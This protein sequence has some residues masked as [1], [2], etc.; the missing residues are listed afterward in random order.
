MI[1]RKRNIFM[2]LALLS[3]I[4]INFS[5]NKKSSAIDPVDQHRYDS[6]LLIERDKALY[7]IDF[8]ISPA[9]YEADIKRFI[10]EH[11]NSRGNLDIMGSEYGV[12]FKCF[13]PEMFYEKNIY[14]DSKFINLCSIEDFNNYENS[15][16]VYNK[17]S[18]MF[19]NGKL[20]SFNIE[21]MGRPLNDSIDIKMN[22]CVS[23]LKKL[24]ESRYGKATNNVLKN[25]IDWDKANPDNVY[26]LEEWNMGAKSVMIYIRSNNSYGNKNVYVGAT[27]IS[28]TI[29]QKGKAYSIKN[30]ISSQTKSNDVVVSEGSEPV[31]SLGTMEYIVES[32]SFAAINKDA[33][34]KLNHVCNVKDQATLLEMISNRLVYVL[35]ANLKVR[36]VDGG[37][38]KSKIR[39][40]EGENEGLEL[41]ISSEFIK[42]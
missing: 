11:S 40:L 7:N 30:N 19:C 14:S 13:R 6:L 3:M 31:E 10:E 32:K 20:F 42:R 17:T 22:Y 24:F 41:Y 4:C 35:P 15:S 2:V 12:Q 25:K 23:G 27:I 9:Q 8:G 26:P 21:T 37:I 34:N 1:M 28:N 38:A 33:F 39:I 16:D 18:T 36:L 29:Y 5:C